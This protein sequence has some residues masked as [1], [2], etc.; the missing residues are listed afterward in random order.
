MKKIILTALAAFTVLAAGTLANP[1]QAQPENTR[2]VVRELVQELLNF[3]KEA[4]LTDAQRTQVKD[5]MKS[6][7]DEIRTQFM[8]GRD[9]RRSMQQ[10]V[11]AGGP[12]STGAQQAAD[13]IAAVARSRALLIAKIT[14]E[15]RPVLTADQLKLAQ[16]TRERIEEIV[17]ER[18]ARFAE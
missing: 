6:H 13:S 4:G 3:R 7:K 1:S 14:S 18:V 16:T 8:S 2:G 17:D 15:I 5:I 9:A 11:E 12:E 10:A